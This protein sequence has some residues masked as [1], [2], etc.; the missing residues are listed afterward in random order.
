MRPL[1]RLA[2]AALALCATPAIAQE[3]PAP[4]PARVQL[5]EK[6]VD[7][8]FP[9]GTYAK[10]M[11]KSMDALMDNIM[12]SVTAMPMRDLAAMGGIDKER[13]DKMGPA[14]MQEVMLILDP[15]FEQR[16]KLT[17]RAMMGEMSGLMTRFEPDI[18]EGLAQAYASRFDARQLAEL[19][20]FFATPTGAAYAEQSMLIFT[21]QAVMT[22]MQ[23]F[24][25][26]MMKQ[27]PA[28]ME[29]V[30]AATAGL[31]EPRKPQDLDK[32][33]RARLAHILGIPEDK[34]DKPGG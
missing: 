19:N 34:L 15:V 25:P 9:S 7:Y 10:I 12:Q 8:V 1:L 31:P 18:R 11:N 28:I 21:D 33:E 17:T 22:R 14:T 6:T 2:S 4:D 32:A 3:T 5:A 13:L 24:M 23:A 16:M 30:K 26:E 27:M 29:K 20:A